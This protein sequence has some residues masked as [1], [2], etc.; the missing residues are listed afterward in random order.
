[1]CF[2]ALDSHEVFLVAA[3]SAR[4]HQRP[5]STFPSLSLMNLFNASPNRKRN[6]EHNSRDSGNGGKVGTPMHYTRGQGCPTVCPS[7]PL[8]P[9][10]VHR[11]GEARP[12]PESDG[13]G[14]RVG[15]DDDPRW[16]TLPPL[17]TECW[18]AHAT[19]HQIGLALQNNSP[20]STR[21]SE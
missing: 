6:G 14:M 21:D 7:F 10:R 16:A 20:P 2:L 9:T 19:R 1:M 18:P 12:T 4:P 17:N 15:A 11:E 3:V 13:R 5:F 8:P